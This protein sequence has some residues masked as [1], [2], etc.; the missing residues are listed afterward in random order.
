MA[1]T[2]MLEGFHVVEI[3]GHQR[4]AG[5]VTT[6]YFGAVALFHVTLDETEWRELTLPQDRYIDH[7]YLHAGSVIRMRG[8]KID[9]AVGA[10][11]IYR[12]SAATE[13]DVRAAQPQDIE[14]LSRAE[15]QQLM[16]RVPDPDAGDDSDFAVDDGF[17]DDEE[18][19]DDGV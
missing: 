10:G 2:P 18:D 9:Q 7:E 8:K 12:I 19:D 15:R 13:E 16:P 3:L 6:K 11:S 17:G 5:Y 1:E 4:V 14:I